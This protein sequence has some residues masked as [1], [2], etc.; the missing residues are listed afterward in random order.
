[1]A[2]ESDRSPTINN[3]NRIKQIIDH[4]LD[5][6][7]DTHPF[8]AAFHLHEFKAWA[9]FPDRRG[10]VAV[11]AGRS[12]TI[13]Y[14]EQIEREYSKK[15]NILRGQKD[16][17]QR[18]IS[19]LKL[20]V[21]EELFDLGVQ[22][23]GGWKAL[24]NCQRPDALREAAKERLIQAQTA[25]DL[26]EL[27]IRCLIHHPEHATL[28][29]LMHAYVLR[30]Y[31]RSLPLLSPAAIRKHW[32]R[33]KQSAVFIYAARSVG[34]ELIPRDA[35]AADFVESSVTDSQNVSHLQTFFGVSAYVAEQ[36]GDEFA[37]IRRCFPDETSLGRIQPKILPLSGEEL[38]ALGAVKSHKLDLAFKEGGR[39]PP[40]LE[41][42]ATR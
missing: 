6:E 39:R 4:L 40:I 18:V 15:R 37:W 21:F 36:F 31:A 29:N 8:I 16:S 26:I 32:R 19:L 13:A 34:F 14:L 24:L 35:S 12:A 22:P 27:R 28:A 33:N 30:W 10:R 38:S 5:P 42:G 1:M 25:A 41:I 23:N 3:Q 17:A 9:C 2:T 20:D 7:D 11:D